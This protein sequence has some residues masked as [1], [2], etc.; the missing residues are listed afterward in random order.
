MR[1]G[2]DDQHLGQSRR[3]GSDQFSEPR[4]TYYEDGTQIRSQSEFP[5]PGTARQTVWSQVL[6]SGRNVNPVEQSNTRDTFV[7]LDTADTMTKAFTPQGLLS[8][9]LQDKQ[10]RSAKRQEELARETG[11]SLI[12]VPNKPPPPQTGLLGAITAH[13]RERKREGGVGAA[14][15]ERERE[16]RLAEERQRRFDEQ[17]RQQMEQMQQSG[18]MYGGYGFNPMM[19]PMMMGM[20]PMMMNPMMTGGG[21]APM[22]TGGGMNPMMTGG[23]MNPMMGYPGML[24]PQQMFAA[25]QAAAAAYQ[26]AMIAFSTAGSQVGGENGNSQGNMQPMGQNMTGGNIPGFDPRMSMMGVPMMGGMNMGMGM[27]PTM[28]GNFDSRFPPGN[29]GSPGATGGENGGLLPPTGPGQFSSQTSSPVGRG[30]PLARP[31]DGSER[32][33]TPKH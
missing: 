5:Q 33:A 16:K 32:P 24:N 14:L 7:Q 18:S 21:M 2:I 25:Q 27:A 29:G 3:L 31:A 9:G 30:S 4:R 1:S 22:M 8:A 6:D 28:T 19:N 15:T 26:Q 10:D 23:G 12:N 17:Q 11:A 20:N 13:E